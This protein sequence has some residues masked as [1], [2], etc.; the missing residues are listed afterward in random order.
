[1][2][3]PPLYLLKP[4]SQGE[5]GGQRAT[6]SFAMGA[7]T[8]S[9]PKSWLS[10]AVVGTLVAATAPI[11]LPLIGAQCPNSAHP[12][13]PET[14]SLKVLTPPKENVQKG[15]STHVKIRNALAMLFKMC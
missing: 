10:S 7:D 4:T 8:D 9:D 6:C 3:P 12:Q 2:P 13:G 14:T 11:T 15:D 1:M 5:E